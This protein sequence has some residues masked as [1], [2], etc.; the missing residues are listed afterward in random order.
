MGCVRGKTQDTRCARAKRHFPGLYTY[1]IRPHPGFSPTSVWPVVLHGSPKQSLLHKKCP[2]PGIAW[3]LPE[4]IAHN[5]FTRNPTSK[6]KSKGLA[7][8]DL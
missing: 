3:R 2:A 8:I 7:V 6:S 5:Y 4:D 1:N